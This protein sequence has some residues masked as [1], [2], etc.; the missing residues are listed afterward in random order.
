MPVASNAG[1][2]SALIACTACT[3][4]RGERGTCDIHG[5]PVT[6]ANLCRSFRRPGQTHVQVRK[7]HPVVGCLKAGIVYTATRS[8]PGGGWTIL[9]MSRLVSVDRKPTLIEPKDVLNETHDIMVLNIDG[10]ES[11]GRFDC[12]ESGLIVLTM[13]DVRYWTKGGDAFSALR[14]IRVDMEL[15]GRIPLVNGA[16]RNAHV[17]GM[18]IQFAHGYRVYLNAP[19][20]EPLVADT[21]GTDHLTDPVFVA[22]Q[23]GARLSET[24]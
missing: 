2:E 21:F 23:P 10:T 24:W 5:T 11:P 3:Y 17:S 14:K 8:E 19:S 9:A 12:Y 1:G 16:N 6:S 15:D 18:A 20:E 13:K 7:E 4:G 22:E